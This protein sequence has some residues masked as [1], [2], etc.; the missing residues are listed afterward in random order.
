LLAC[1][2]TGRGAE[3]LVIDDEFRAMSASANL[4][5]STLQT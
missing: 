1:F 4:A 2:Q 5:F 3:Q